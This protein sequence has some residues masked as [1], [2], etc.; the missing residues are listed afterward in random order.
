MSTLRPKKTKIEDTVVSAYHKIEDTVV[1]T[2][3]KIEDAVVG[4]YQKIEDKF[5]EKLLE[6]RD[7]TDK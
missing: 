6:E 5:V 1:G 7:D 4:T 2:Y 3:Q